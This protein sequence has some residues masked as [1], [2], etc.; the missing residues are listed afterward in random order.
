MFGLL[1]VGV[2][3]TSFVSL[4]LWTLV[5]F[6]RDTAST[7]K[8]GAQ[9]LGY[10]VRL[11]A[12]AFTE[13]TAPSAA[14]WRMGPWQIGIG[15]VSLAMIASVFTPGT[16]WFLHATAA[17][18]AIVLLGYARMII[19]GLTMEIVCLPFLAVWFVYYAACLLRAASVP[20]R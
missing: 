10:V 6:V 20:S 8:Q 19:A 2:G 13:G 4:V 17:F 5:M 7:A 15:L 1:R 18:A 3:L 11:F 9:V 12:S 14:P 16:R